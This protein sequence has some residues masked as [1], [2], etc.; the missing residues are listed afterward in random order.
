MKTSL[1]KFITVAASACLF[2]LPL[3]SSAGFCNTDAKSKRDCLLCKIGEG[4]NDETL[5]KNAKGPCYWDTTQETSPYT[6][7]E[8]EGGNGG[9]DDGEGG[10]NGRN[11]GRG[12][13]FLR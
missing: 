12:P 5:C 6:S 7:Q 11:G 4:Q 3:L 2:L 10:T 13:R 1:M 9:T 8:C